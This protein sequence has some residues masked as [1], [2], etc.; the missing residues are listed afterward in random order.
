[1]LPSRSGPPRGLLVALLITAATFAGA[2]VALAHAELTSS[3]PA[4]DASVAGPYAGPVEVRF[5]E[6]V[7]SSSKF[8][9]VAPDGSI[10]ATGRPAPADAAILTL[11]LATPLDPAEYTVRWTSVADDGHVERGT[12]RFIVTAEAS[13]S[14]A[15]SASASAGPPGSSGGASPTPADA[16]PDPGA[17]GTSGNVVLPIAVGLAGVAVLGAY[18]VRRRGTGR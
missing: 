5:S 7:E 8:D 16:T 3:T 1:M 15:P 18:L 6:A 10:V 2:P 11:T 9:L 17:T 14:P 12:F 4:A 13:A